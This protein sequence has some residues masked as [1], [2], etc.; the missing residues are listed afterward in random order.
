MAVYDQSPTIGPMTIERGNPTEGAQCP[1]CPAGTLK[2]G[3]T[4]VTMERDGATIV[5][6]EVPADVCDTCGEAY[7]DED[8]SN[9]LYRQAEDAVEA[10]VEVDV[11]R[12]DSRT[13]ATA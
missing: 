7:L 12:Y 5:F 8:V 4:T 3:T 9:R 1:M 2:K 13:E 10:G 6:K 11:R